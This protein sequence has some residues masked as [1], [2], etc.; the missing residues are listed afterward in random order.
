MKMANWAIIGAATVTVVIG[1]LYLGGVIAPSA[2]EDAAVPEEVAPQNAPEADDGPERT[3]TVQNDPQAPRIDL[4]RLEPDGSAILA[5][6][7]PPGW[8]VEILLDGTGFADAEPGADGAFAAFLDLPSSDAARVLSLRATGPDGAEPLTGPSEIIVTPAAPAPEPSVPPDLTSRTDPDLQ[9]PV[10]DVP[11]EPAAYGA[12]QDATDMAARPE[13]TG[14]TQENTLPFQSDTSALRTD[15]G[16]RSAAPADA[17]NAPQLATATPG[18]QTVL[19]ADAS[20]IEVLQQPGLTGAPRAMTSVA[21]DAISYSEAGDV[22]LSGRAVGQGSIR[23]YLDNRPVVTSRITE[24][25]RW[26]TALPQVESGIYTLRVDELDDAGRVTSR[27]ETPFKREDRALL[28][29]LQDAGTPPD[30]VTATTGNDGEA[31]ASTQ[32]TITAPVPGVRAMTVQPGN[33]LWAISRETYGEGILYVRVFE[34]NADRIRDPD[35]IYPGQ[36]FTLP[37]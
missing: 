17:S 13:K 29:E 6:A 36:V 10:P 7:A 15:P 24:A 30:T 3:D 8:S 19:R 5:G 20:G 25:G 14:L 26:R 32:G 22:Q 2:P 37:N 28:A 34:A 23:V 33:T 12:L 31:R 16:R 9:R 4:F 27:V 1:G 35:L 11:A 21:L 18:N